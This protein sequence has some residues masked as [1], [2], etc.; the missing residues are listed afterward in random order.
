MKEIMFS[1]PGISRSES[2][3]SLFFLYHRHEL[4]YWL[5]FVT[6]SNTR[7]NLRSNCPIWS[8]IL[9]RLSIIKSA[10]RELIN[11][12]PPYGSRL[13]SNVCVQFFYFIYLFDWH[14]LILN[15][16][17]TLCVKWYY[18]KAT[19]RQSSMNLF[20]QRVQIYSTFL[21]SPVILPRS[22]IF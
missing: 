13:I 2:Q 20:H 8:T 3:C 14:K 21:P 7:R 22:L 19:S 4:F 12:P 16:S 9:R 5:H 6:A 11:I 1:F 17:C 10:A 15:G 18:D